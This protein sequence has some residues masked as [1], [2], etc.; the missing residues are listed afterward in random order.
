MCLLW[1]YAVVPAGDW[2]QDF[3]YARQALYQ[4]SHTP[5]L[6][7]QTFLIIYYTGSSALA[8]SQVGED[9]AFRT[10][11]DTASYLFSITCYQRVQHFLHTFL[12]FSAS[13]QNWTWPL[14]SYPTTTRV[15]SYSTVCMPPNVFY[16][17]KCAASLWD[18]CIWLLLFFCLSVLKLN[19]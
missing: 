14:G 19:Q 4:V 17:L 13:P 16:F 12:K 15:Q 8:W 2:A 7:T 6:F 9:S 5:I 3:V 18:L 1:V 10:L 11:N